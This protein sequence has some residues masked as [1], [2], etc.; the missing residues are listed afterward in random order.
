MKSIVG[1]LRRQPSCNRRFIKLL[2][3]SSGPYARRFEAHPSGAFRQISLKVDPLTCG[4][5]IRLRAHGRHSVAQT[6]LQAAERLPFET[7]DGIAGR[8][9]LRNRVTAEALACK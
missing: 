6:S 8:M 7:V 9:R 3:K 2:N 1:D 5:R 4:V